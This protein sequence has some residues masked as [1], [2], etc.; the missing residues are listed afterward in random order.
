M[1]SIPIELTLAAAAASPR[2]A[3]IGRTR[4]ISPEGLYMFSDQPLELAPG[5]TVSVSMVVP[6]SERRTV[7]F[8]RMSGLCRVLRLEPA[9]RDRGTGWGVALAFYPERFNM[10]GTVYA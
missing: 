7:P 6:M 2:Q 5:D 4:D 1:V 10:I 9:M 8:A 3:W